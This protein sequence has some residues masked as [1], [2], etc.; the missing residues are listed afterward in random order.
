MAHDAVEL[1]LGVLLVVALAVDTDT[2]AVGNVLD[3]ASPDSLVQLGV[4]AHVSSA[5]G[6]GDVGDDGLDG[7]G[8]ALLE[9]PRGR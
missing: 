7:G 6:L 3:A 2:D 4:N 8:G 5:H 1:V 9:G